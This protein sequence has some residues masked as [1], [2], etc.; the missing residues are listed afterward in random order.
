MDPILQK[1]LPIMRKHFPDVNVYEIKSFNDGHDHF[2]FLLPN[3]VAFRFPRGEEYGKKDAVIT[4]FLHEFAK[5]SPIPIQVFED[6][7]DGKAG[8]YQTYSFIQGTK[9][10][11][12][13]ANRFSPEERYKVA[14]QLGEFLKV[15]HAY[16]VH[17]AE[18]IGAYKID[19]NGYYEYFESIWSE[20]KKVVY[21]LIDESE[22][23]Y[24]DKVFAAY[25]QTE[26]TAFIPV[27]THDDV[28]PEHIIV[29]EKRHEINGIIDFSLRIADPARDFMFLHV[30]GNDF[31]E[32]ALAWY[33]E[34]D[35]QFM[36]RRE[37]YGANFYVMYLYNAITKGSNKEKI[38][39]YRNALSS[40]IAGDYIPN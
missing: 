8:N 16:S 35:N 26:R 37:F 9:F 31:L 39:Q 25:M 10:L 29:D 23:Q 6:N 18:E 13:V 24:L 14:K 1:Y 20:D 27:V 17:K 4:A 11:P 34:V 33:G 21:P 28:L 22:R 2:V 3:G 40:Y 15:L 7:I 5:Q 12:E 36:K 19:V 30:Y 32:E 38:K